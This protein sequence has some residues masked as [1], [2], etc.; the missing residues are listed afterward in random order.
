MGNT[1]EPEIAVGIPKEFTDAERAVF[2]ELVRAGEE[3]GGKILERNV[4]DARAL[5]MLKHAGNILGVAALK[6]PQ[7]SYRKRISREAGAEIVAETF[8]YE[9]G[10]I[11]LSPEVRGKR[12]SHRL[13]AAVL[14]L[15]DG[16]GVFATTRRD[17]HPMLHT[18]AKSGF[19]MVG[20]PY[21]SK[22]DETRMIRLLLRSPK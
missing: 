16:A 12:Q 11:Y 17:N 9:L 20:A 7:A 14:K 22:G 15:S 2:A 1:E 4:A 6:R 13:V 8:P 10:Y 18:L 21:Q 3:V 5:A 19:E